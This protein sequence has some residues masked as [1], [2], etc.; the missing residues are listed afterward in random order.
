MNLLQHMTGDYFCFLDGDDFYT[1]TEFVAQALELYRQHEGMSVIAFGYQHFSDVKGILVSKML[2]AG[3]MDTRFYLRSCF[4]HAGACVL[5]NCFTQERLDWLK[6]IGYYDDN[7]IL[8]NNLHFGG[9]Y[10]VNRPVYGYRQ[11]DNSTYNAMNI[12]EQAV[13]NVQ[14]WDVDRL[15]LPEHARD[16]AVR[17][18]VCL[19]QM[20][21]LRHRLKALLG[22]EKHER[23][24]QGCRTIPNS[25]AYALLAGTALSADD[26]KLLCKVLLA[27]PKQTLRVLLACGKLH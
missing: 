16:L 14:G 21:F 7:N 10:A 24:L 15:L 8:I 20:Y 18:G 27:H 5:K 12:A 26:R 3:V 1:D 13:L 11:T 17:Y 6:D 25:M 9:M 4:T 19:K 2:S 23:Y 22:A